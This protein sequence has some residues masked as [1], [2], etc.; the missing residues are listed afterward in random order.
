MTKSLDYYDPVKNL[1]YKIDENLKKT[2]SKF[3]VI[4]FTSDW[5][6]PPKRSK[7]I[8]KLL[9]NSERD[10]SYCEI[11]ADGGHDAFLMVN[12]DYFDVMKNFINQVCDG[13]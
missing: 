1:G 6:F 10:V 13:I 5:R 12:K 4:S 2:K 9:L 11:D 3:L 8:V 7:E